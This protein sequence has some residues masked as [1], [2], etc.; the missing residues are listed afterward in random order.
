MAVERVLA[1][2]RLV[3]RLLR[4]VQDLPEDV[5]DVRVLRLLP[6]A[7]TVVQ[8]ATRWEIKLSQLK[9]CLGSSHIF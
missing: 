3:Q 4:Y 2:L 6:A 8:P 5:V 9:S 1:R 7:A